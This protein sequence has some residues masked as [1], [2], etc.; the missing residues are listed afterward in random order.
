MGVANSL[1]SFGVSHPGAITLHN[2]P[3]FLQEL[4]PPDGT[5]LDLAAVDIMRI[6]ERGVPRYND[7]RELFHKRRVKS[8]EELAEEPRDGRGARARLRRRRQRST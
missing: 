5:V 4:K 3:R 2:Y 7:F 8:F 1:Y 6:R